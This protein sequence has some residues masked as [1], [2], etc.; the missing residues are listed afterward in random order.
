MASSGFAA[1]F[2]AGIGGS[3]AVAALS[4]L[5]Y[6][7]SG[8]YNVAATEPHFPAMRWALD[9][10]YH[11]SVESRSAN[12]RAPE[13]FTPETVS[14]GAGRYA[15][16]CAHCH[17]GP[18]AEPAGWSRG[19]RPEPPHLWRA[20]SEW[21][22]QEVFWLVKN[23]VKMSGMPAFGPDHDDAAIWEITAFV[24]ELPGMQPETYQ[25]LTGGEDRGRAAQ[26]ATSE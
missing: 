8:S 15:E 24:K 10:S 11:A 21:E 17:G 23:G 16:M 3:I 26:Q 22:S 9:T 12:I 4:G 13:D 19:M 7:Y 20:A 2:A 25:N 5:I 18:G 1:R 6:V 14:A